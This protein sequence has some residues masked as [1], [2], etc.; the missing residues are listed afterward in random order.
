MIE[1]IPGNSWLVE[2]GILYFCTNFSYEDRHPDH[3]SPDVHRAF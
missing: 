1:L 3:I 2:A